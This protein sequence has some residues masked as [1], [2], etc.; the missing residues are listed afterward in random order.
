MVVGDGKKFLCAL[1]TLKTKLDPKGE[2][3]NELEDQVL[4]TFKSLQ[5]KAKTI[6]QA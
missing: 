6:K 5:S 2:L 3:T 1:L 4:E